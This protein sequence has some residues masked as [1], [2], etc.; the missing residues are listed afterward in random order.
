MRETCESSTGTSKKFFETQGTLRETTA[1]K[2]RTAQSEGLG[3]SLTTPALYYPD[4]TQRFPSPPQP[5]KPKK[6]QISRPGAFSFHIWCTRRD[7][8][9]RPLPSEGKIKASGALPIPST[10]RRSSPV[11]SAESCPYSCFCC[12]LAVTDRA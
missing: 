3:N 1:R 11:V 4:P 8:N 5:Q 7:S 9:P 10:L 12:H 6:P 2:S